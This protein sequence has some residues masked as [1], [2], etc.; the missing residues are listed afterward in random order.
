[1]ADPGSDVTIDDLIARATMG[2]IAHAYARGL[3]TR[4][5]SLLRSIFLEEFVL[6]MESW[7]WGAT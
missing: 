6:D 4:D 1:M 7:V 2:D 3:D 5:A